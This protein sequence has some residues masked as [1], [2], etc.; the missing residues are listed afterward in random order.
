MHPL[1]VFDR[2][3]T[4]GAFP[5]RAVDR[6]DSLSIEVGEKPVDLGVD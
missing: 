5:Q 1:E 3:R 4:V 2:R 6:L